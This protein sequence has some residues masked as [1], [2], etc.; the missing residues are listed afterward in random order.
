MKIA[1]TVIAHNEEENIEKC[2][3]SA[4]SQTLKPDEI[5]VVCH[6]CSD[7]T[8][9][10]VNKFKEVKAVILNGPAGAVYARAKAY[11]MVSSDIDI[12]AATDG[13]CFLSKKWLE[14]QIKPFEDE[15]VVATGGAIYFSNSFY[16]NLM[17]LSF[18][19]FEPLFRRNFVYYFWGAN[20]AFRKDTYKI[21]DGFKG[22]IELRK[23]KNLHYW[24]EDQYSS[25]LL[26][27]FGTV[28]FV[29]NS[30]AWTKSPKLNLWQW[31]KRGKWQDEDRVKIFKYFG[32]E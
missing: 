13:D 6:N 31:L 4:L 17:S 7:N 20:H 21:T 32:L 29:S 30:V 27:K 5:I 18:F 1:L 3:L 16:A 10:I 26:N 28:K 24:A 12:I 11:E 19:F 25:L 23:E 2:L 14:N 15:K 9:E 22:L 8:V